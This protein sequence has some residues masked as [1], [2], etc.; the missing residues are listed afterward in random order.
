MREALQAFQ[1]SFVQPQPES[2]DEEVLVFPL[3]QGGQFGIREEENALGLLFKHVQSSTSATSSRPL[4]DLTSGYFSLYQ[5]YQK[6]ILSSP[7]L[8]CRIVAA[9]PQANGFYGS[10][11]LSGYI[12]EGYTLYE[13]RFIHAVKQ[14]GRL[15][16]AVPESPLGGQGVL[17]SEWSKPGWTYHAK[18]TH[19]SLPFHTPDLESRRAYFSSLFFS[20][21]CV[22]HPRWSS[23]IW[24][25]PDS[26]SQPILT[27]FGSTNL[28]A[29]S[30]HIDTELSFMMVLPTEGRQQGPENS[31]AT[32]RHALADEIAKIRENTADWQGWRRK[33]RKTTRM[34]VWLIKGML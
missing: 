9:S 17:L 16:R 3:I 22:A 25:S 34:L 21:G 15:W 19:P 2:S 32:L 18:G 8:D 11:G 24:L 13:Q 23:G 30:A 14:A 27:L 6:M 26:I 1:T 20:F 4:L 7:N 28:N 10:A 12:P 5:P 29:R 31:V 33:I